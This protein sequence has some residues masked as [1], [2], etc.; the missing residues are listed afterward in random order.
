MSKGSRAAEA[1]E[2]HVVA[3]QGHGLPGPLLV[4][5]ELT[6]L[7][8]AVRGRRPSFA[9]CGTPRPPVTALTTCRPRDLALHFC[10]LQS[11][12]F[13]FLQIR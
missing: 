2:T 12:L 6:Q 1:A 7:V 4:S 13:A 9:T 5:R 10:R 8:A 11:A 3:G